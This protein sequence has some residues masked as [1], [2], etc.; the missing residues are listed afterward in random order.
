MSLRNAK[1]N[2]I[3]AVVSLILFPFGEMR[4]KIREGKSSRGNR[5][6]GRGRKIYF[7]LKLWRKIIAFTLVKPKL[8]NQPANM[9]KLI[10]YSLLVLKKCIAAQ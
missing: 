6:K 1:I 8:S 3:Y 9:F 4:K 2:L 10:K 7:S 5:I